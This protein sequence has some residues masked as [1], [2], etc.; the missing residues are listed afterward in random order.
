MVFCKAGVTDG[1]QYLLAEDP[2]LVLHWLPPLSL[3]D[4]NNAIVGRGVIHVIALGAFRGGGL[5]DH[6]RLLRK[7]IKGVITCGEGE[8][9]AL[10][11]VRCKL[12]NNKLQ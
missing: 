11:T 12:R 3:F 4:C 5:L 6:R 9:R 1:P 10:C 8:L 7:L 2:M